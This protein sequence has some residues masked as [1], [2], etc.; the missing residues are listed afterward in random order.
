MYVV[1]L[2]RWHSP[3]LILVCN[4]A[5]PDLNGT[6]NG[7][8]VGAS[9]PSSVPLSPPPKKRKTEERSPKIKKSGSPR[10]VVGQ[11]NVMDLD[12]LESSGVKQVNANK[13]KPS[14]K[15]ST[16]K[17]STKRS[18]LDQQIAAAQKAIAQ[19]MQ[20]DDD[21]TKS[22][23][24]KNRVKKTSPSGT[25]RCIFDSCHG[26]GVLSCILLFYS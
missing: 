5:A 23:T 8:E 9:E 19:L 18:V 16:A 26:F 10:S 6:D 17:S 3:I 20:D 13:S 11:Y 14:S 24:R 15:I 22:A 7:I 25:P 12:A 2:K 21:K 4:Y 1:A